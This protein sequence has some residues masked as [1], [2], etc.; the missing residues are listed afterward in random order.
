MLPTRMAMFDT[1]AI[2]A[3]KNARKKNTGRAR[4]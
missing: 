3:R 1:G 4:R 2:A